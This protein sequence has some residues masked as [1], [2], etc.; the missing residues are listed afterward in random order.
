[1][2]AHQFVLHPI[3]VAMAYIELF[4][5]PW[6]PQVWLSFVIHDLGYA[7]CKFNGRLGCPNMDGQEGQT[8]PEWA[9][10][11]MHFLFDD[12]YMVQDYCGWH[13]ERSQNWK[14]FCLYHSR[15]YV[16]RFGGELSDLFA[17]D[18][19][20]FVYQSKRLYLWG[21]RITGELDEYLANA[22]NSTGHNV[23]S[24]NIDEWYET[25]CKHMSILAYDYKR[26]KDAKCCL[27]LTN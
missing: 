3:C 25:M 21:T 19:L 26:E 11:V 2:G 17:A 10:G 13:W 4:G 23:R 1:M 14:N 24:G 15:F 27:Q 12:N 16:R 22:K 8:H 20:A 7:F 5:F 9:A 18:K 6:R